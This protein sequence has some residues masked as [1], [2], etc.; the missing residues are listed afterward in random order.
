MNMEVVVISALFRDYM[1]SDTSFHPIPEHEAA[2]NDDVPSAPTHSRTSE[3]SSRK[4]KPP[5]SDLLGELTG[6]I[7][8]ILAHFFQGFSL[9]DLDSGDILLL[10]ILL[11]LFLEGDNLDLVIALGLMFLLSFSADP[12]PFT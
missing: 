10:L 3:S 12:H 1:P 7:Q 4:Q 6:G 8:E 9:K 5:D 2:A 11:F